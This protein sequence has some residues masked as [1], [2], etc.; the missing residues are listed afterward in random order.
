LSQLSAIP[1]RESEIS[2]RIAAL[3]QQKTLEAIREPLF[4]YEEDEPLKLE[5]VWQL[6]GRRFLQVWQL[7]H[8]HIASLR[9]ERS[10]LDIGMGFPVFLIRTWF[11]IQQLLIQSL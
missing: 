6:S 10:T 4:T 9:L 8:W 1:S 11:C 5:G 2:Q 3:K 7:H